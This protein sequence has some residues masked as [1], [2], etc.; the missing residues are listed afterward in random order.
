MGIETF[1]RYQSSF[2]D[3]KSPAWDPCATLEI[4]NPDRG[5]L[6]CVGYAPSQRRRCRNPIAA[7]NRSCV[8]K[9]LEALANTSPDSRSIK[10]QLEQIAAL[11]LCRRY[12]Q[13]QIDSVVDQWLSRITLMRRRQ[14]SQFDYEDLDTHHARPKATRGSN[15]QSW[16]SKS[17]A[18][19]GKP[20]TSK[21]NSQ[22]REQDTAERQQREDR[23]RREQKRREAERAEEERQEREREASAERERQNEKLRQQAA[24]RKREERQKQAH[25]KAEQE[26][27]TWDQA[28]EDYVKGWAVFKGGQSLSSILQFCHY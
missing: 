16:S 22:A 27:K 1:P 6:T 25:G 24:Q 10:S 8:Y 18:P 21:S 23:R 28:W 5:C 11:S 17:H 3:H 20:Q 14:S 15:W 7:G 2:I 19:E 4:V 9:M 13:N 12:H 26:R